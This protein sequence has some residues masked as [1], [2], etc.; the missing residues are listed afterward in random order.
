MG[1]WQM[2]GLCLEEVVDAMTVIRPCPLNMQQLAAPA[3][4]GCET[5]ALPHYHILLHVC[6]LHT[7]PDTQ[8]RL[9]V[10][11]GHQQSCWG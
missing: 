5:A 4:R 10:I 9:L 3:E 8:Q 1:W 6:S 2:G 7:M 11:L